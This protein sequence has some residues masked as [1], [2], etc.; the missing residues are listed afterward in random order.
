MFELYE[1][2]TLVKN[3]NGGVWPLRHRDTQCPPYFTNTHQAYNALEAFKDRYPDEVLEVQQLLSFASPERLASA[4]SLYCSDGPMKIYFVDENGTVHIATLDG[5]EINDDKALRK[6]LVKCVT[7]VYVT[8]NMS[9]NSTK[10]ALRLLVEDLSRV[11]WAYEDNLCVDMS[12]SLEPGADNV[13]K[14]V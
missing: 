14:I 10:P 8:I 12:F 7:G 9:E 4:L 11:Y 13:V 6:P 5:F 2:V 1:I 3:T